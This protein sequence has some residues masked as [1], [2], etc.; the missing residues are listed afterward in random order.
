MVNNAERV[1][2]T[3]LGAVT[4]YGIDINMYR[5]GL[6]Q[7]RPAWQLQEEWSYPDIG[8]TAI[9]RTP[10]FDRKI[11]LPYLRPPVPSRYCQM[12]LIAAG[13]ALDD[14]GVEFENS[15]RVGTVLATEFGPNESVEKHLTN[16]M[17]SGPTATSPI[18]FSGTVMN[19][20]LGEI[21][22][23]WNLR[24]PSTA[25]LGEQ[26]AIY[27]FDLLRQGKAD[28]ILCGG[29]DEVRDVHVWAFWEAGVLPGSGALPPPRQHCFEPKAEGLVMGDGSAFLLMERLETAHQR[30]ANV[31]AEMLG[32]GSVRDRGKSHFFSSR[33]ANDIEATMRTALSDADIAPNLVTHIILGANTHAGTFIPEQEAIR[34]VFS[35][36]SLKPE[37]VWPKAV[38]GETFGSSGPLAIATAADILRNRE[39]GI[40]LVNS[41]HGGNGNNTVILCSAGIK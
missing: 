38:V 30:G 7:H 37:Q 18:T 24:G 32:W 2:F 8:L 31:Y 6:A 39:D 26:P 25:V 27:A 35:S 33:S 21:A 29:V 12:A 14:A 15:D 20:A 13:S 5:Q 17:R 3:G 40:C 4:S 22:R 1:G 9:A 19:V 36:T 34:S 11:H 23:H 28:A 41:L 16:L 10:A